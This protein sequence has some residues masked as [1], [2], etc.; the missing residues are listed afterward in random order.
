MMTVIAAIAIVILA[1]AAALYKGRTGWHWSVLALVAFGV[2]WL[3]TA[4]TLLVAGVHQSLSAED[5][6]L[7]AFAGGLTAAVVLVILVAVPF[8]PK[9]RSVPLDAPE[10][11][12]TR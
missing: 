12:R 3:L 10:R 7:A 4:A 6:N 11:E 2:L 9:R 1:Y 5:R 8:R